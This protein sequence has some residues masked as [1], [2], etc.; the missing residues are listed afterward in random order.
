MIH[1]APLPMEFLLFLWH[2]CH[3]CHR[4]SFMSGALL[5]FFDQQLFTPSC[6]NRLLSCGS[7]SMCGIGSSGG[8]LSIFMDSSSCHKKVRT[9]WSWRRFAEPL[10][11]IILKDAPYSLMSCQPIRTVSI[12]HS[13]IT[14]CSSGQ[15]TTSGLTLYPKRMR[16]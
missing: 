3:S 4:V 1:W 15:G 8:A 14:L 6:W 11:T 16:R 9:R 2:H 5:H 13:G 12:C 10:S 7:V